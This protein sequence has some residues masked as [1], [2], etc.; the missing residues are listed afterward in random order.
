M[1]IKKDAD[2][3]EAAIERCEQNIEVVKVSNFSP[4]EKEDLVC[5]Y[6]NQIKAYKEKLMS[7]YQTAE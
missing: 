3:Y 2:W 4:K 7:F 5:S 1:L 6:I